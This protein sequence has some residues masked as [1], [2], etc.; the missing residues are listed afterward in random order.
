MQVVIM[1]IQHIYCVMNIDEQQ[2][3]RLQ[4]NHTLQLWC[5]DSASELTLSA[6]GVS[7]GQVQN[8]E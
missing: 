7:G 8:H 1:I 2:L 5:D 3:T 6:S 4:Q